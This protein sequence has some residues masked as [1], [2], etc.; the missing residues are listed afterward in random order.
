MCP[1]DSHLE[2]IG[3]GDQ[4]GTH[5]Q[6]SAVAREGEEPRLE[7]EVRVGVSFPRRGWRGKY[8]PKQIS[9]GGKE[10]TC[11]LFVCCRGR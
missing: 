5:F 8:Q 3:F 11:G 2:T 4:S 1:T 6:E 7:A 10:F 9:Y